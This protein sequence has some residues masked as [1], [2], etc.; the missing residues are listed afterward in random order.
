MLWCPG[1]GKYHPLALEQFRYP[2]E[3]RKANGKWNYEMVE[4]DAW[5]ECPHG[6]GYQFREPDKHRAYS[7]DWKASKDHPARKWCFDTK[8]DFEAELSRLGPDAMREV[9]PIFWL[10]TNEDAPRSHASYHLPS[11]YSPDSKCTIGAVVAQKLRA[12]SSGSMQDVQDFYNQT[13]AEAFDVVLFGVSSITDLPKGSYEMGDKWE[14]AMIHAIT[15]TEVRIASVDR[16]ESS[17]WVVVRTLGEDGSTRLFW[18]GELTTFDEVDAECKKMGVQTVLCDV[19]Y[20]MKETL[21]E[22]HDRGWIG[23]RGEDRQHYPVM[24]KPSKEFPQGRPVNHIY[25]WATSTA[26]SGRKVA[27]IGWAKQ[28]GWDQLA[29]LIANK[30]GVSWTI[31]QTPPEFY[32]K[33]VT[34]KSYMVVKGRLMW[35]TR[36]HKAHD[37]CGDCEAQIGVWQVADDLLPGHAKIVGGE[38][39]EAN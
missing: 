14:D 37:H 35:A 11:W 2:Q 19:S 4:K 34:A 23:M 21:D 39:V 16:Q 33:Q 27:W 3:A 22:C 24:E 30:T 9:Y 32:V 1:C 36:D 26:A 15:K 12:E 25:R 28:G 8:E 13:A 10:P 17:F 29:A 6:C 31:C 7:A 18:A 20:K 5:H 38:E